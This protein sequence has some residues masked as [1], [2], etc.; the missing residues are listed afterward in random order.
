MQRRSRTITWDEVSAAVCGTITLE[1]RCYPHS[2]IYR[3]TKRHRSDDD[4]PGYWGDP[5]PHGDRTL[6]RR[7]ERN[8]P[9]PAHR[10][11]HRDATYRR[12]GTPWGGRSLRGRVARCC[13]SRRDAHGWRALRGLGLYAG[14]QRQACAYW[15]GGDDRRGGHRKEPRGSELWR[16]V[17]AFAPEETD[18]RDGEPMIEVGSRVTVVG[19]DEGGT[20]QVV[21][22]ERNYHN[23]S[24]DLKG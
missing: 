6:Y 19:F 4:I 21:S 3:P 14:L 9:W 12:P 17:L 16:A 1:R 23:R 7:P 15:Q 24:L 5:D 22:V 13:C 11:G 10:G 8:Q 18:P 2:Y 20:V